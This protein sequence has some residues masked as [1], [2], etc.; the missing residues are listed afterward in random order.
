MPA[1]LICNPDQKGTPTY[2]LDLANAII[3]ILDKVKAAQ[4]KDEYVGVYHLRFLIG[5]IPWRSVLLILSRIVRSLLKNTNHKV[6]CS[7]F[8]VQSK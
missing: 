1:R 3:T 4:S 7:I 5:W 8:K 6:Q 2:A